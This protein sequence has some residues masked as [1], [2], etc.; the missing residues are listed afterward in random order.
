M[1]ERKIPKIELL[2]HGKCNGQFEPVFTGTDYFGFKHIRCKQFS[3]IVAV[4]IDGVGRIVYN[5]NCN[6]CN[7]HDALKVRPH[8]IYLTTKFLRSVDPGG[9]FNYNSLG[10]GTKINHIS[11]HVRLVINR[12]NRISSGFRPS[13]QR[14]DERGETA[15]DAPNS[16]KKA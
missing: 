9:W 3:E 16:G 2:W 8:L 15:S 4:T 12:P 5:L 13:I 1:N 6:T 7:F 10:D 11:D 14:V